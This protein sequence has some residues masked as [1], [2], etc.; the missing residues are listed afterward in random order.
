MAELCTQ[1]LKNISLVW[2]RPLLRTFKRISL[3]KME[4]HLPS[5]RIKCSDRRHNFILNLKCKY[6]WRR[7]NIWISRFI[8]SPR[9]KQILW[10]NIKYKITSPHWAD[11]L[12]HLMIDVNT[13]S[14]PILA[15]QKKL[16]L[17]NIQAFIRKSLNLCL[18]A[19]HI[20][21]CCHLVRFP[22]LGPSSHLRLESLREIQQMFVNS[23]RNSEE[24]Q[25]NTVVEYKT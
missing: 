15:L 14:V 13:A 17:Y 6:C 4:T 8:N 18:Q 11:F 23:S 5:E 3:W 9:R 1:I 25:E 21:P 20:Y 10:I 22:V 7:S 2:T 24:H 12:C 19:Y 16:T